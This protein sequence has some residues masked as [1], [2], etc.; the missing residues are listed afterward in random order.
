MFIVLVCF[1]V[2]Q[3][4]WRMKW[5]G[6]G[7]SGG[8]W[9]YERKKL[10]ENANKPNVKTNGGSV[11]SGTKCKWNEALTIWFVWTGQ[12]DGSERMVTRNRNEKSHARMLL[13]T[14]VNVC[15]NWKRDWTKCDTHELSRCVRARTQATGR[16]QQLQRE[17][18]I[19][20]EQQQESTRVE[21]RKFTRKKKCRYACTQATSSPT[22][23]NYF[24][25][26]AVSAPIK[27]KM[28]GFAY[29]LLYFVCKSKKSA[30]SRRASYIHINIYV[31]RYIYTIYTIALK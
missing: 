7:K 5:A 23:C 18:G 1:D 29:F 28:W 27:C 21:M 26:C 4:R 24:I 16:E 6:D 8:G 13:W 12:K 14:D 25:F 20:C 15:T 31:K 2:N 30:C 10:E 22:I 19:E 3:R 11:K 9:K 17:K